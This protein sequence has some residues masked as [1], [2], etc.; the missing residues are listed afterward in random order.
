MTSAGNKMNG[1]MG[2]SPTIIHAVKTADNG[3]TFLSESKGNVN[4][5]LGF[6]TVSI[7]V[8]IDETSSLPSSSINGSLDSPKLANGGNHENGDLA[9]NGQC[10]VTANFTHNSISASV[11]ATVNNNNGCSRVKNG[12]CDPK[13]EN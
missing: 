12:H 8:S 7:T 1:T 11:S 3:T 10:H 4:G 5:G 6:R 13:M 9:V 2:D